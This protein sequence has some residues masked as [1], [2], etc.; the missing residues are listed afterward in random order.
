[1]DQAIAMFRE[2]AEQ[3]HLFSASSL[4]IL[5]GKGW[6]VARDP[7]FGF[8]YCKKAAETGDANSQKNLAISYRDGYGCEANPEK[9]ADWFEKAALQGDVE[10]ME[11]LGCMYRDGFGRKQSF[12]H[13]AEWFEPAARQGNARAETHLGSLL[14]NGRGVPADPARALELFKKGAAQ[15]NTNALANIG[16]CHELCLGGATKDY[17]EARKYYE[18]AG[19]NGVEHLDRLT[20]RIRSEIPVLGKRVIIIDTNRDELDGRLGMAT[21]FKHAPEQLVVRW[22]ADGT[23][24]ASTSGH[25]PGRYVVDLD[26][27]T[28]VPIGDPALRV[29]H[30]TTQLLLDPENVAL[31]TKSKRKKKKKTKKK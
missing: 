15:G 19:A 8:V 11:S 3:G 2:A 7:R 20:K 1:M 27:P 29:G 24:T 22:T 4:M 21:S 26:S 28:F 16:I 10:S 25:A 12:E 17:V 30:L 23:G 13:A 6:G 14:L 18:R 31:Y 5:Y 9:A